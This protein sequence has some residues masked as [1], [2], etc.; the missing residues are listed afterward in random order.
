[1]G[2]YL[3]RASGPFRAGAVITFMLVASSVAGAQPNTPV[4]QP[5]TSKPVTP[6]PQPPSPTPPVAKPAVPKPDAPKPDAPKGSPPKPKAEQPKKVA[7]TNP[8]ASK[9]KKNKP[10]G[11]HGEVI[12]VH[13]EAPVRTKPRSSG[14]FTVDRKVIEAAP[15]AE[16]A[17]VLRTAPGLY[18][19][20]VS[21]ATAHRY[22]LRGFDAEHGQDLELRVGELPINLPSHIHGQG[23]ADLSFLI[24]EVV[25]R[26]DVAEGVYDPR[27]GDFGVAGSINASLG[28]TRRGIHVKSSLGRFG[29]SRHLLLWAPPKHDAHTFGAVQYTSTDGFGQNR[30]GQSVSAMLQTE[31]KATLWHHRLIGLVYGARSD[32]AGVLRRDDVAA[33]LVDFYGVYNQATARAQNALSGRVMLGLFSSYRGETGDGGGTGLW[34]GFDDFRLMSNFTGFLERS[35]TLENVAGRGDL[36]EQLNRT[37]SVGIN[38]HY[39]TKTFRP[40]PALRG[41]FELGTDA[42]FHVID[43]QQNL[44]DAAVRNQTWDNRVDANVRMADV[45]FWVD[46]DW[47]L[48]KRVGLRAGMRADAL[49]FDVEDRL[50]NF[51]PATRPDDSFIMG[52]RR[53]AFGLAA[54]P[55]ASADYWATDNLQLRVAYGEGFRSP[56][57][58][59]LEDGERAPFTKVRSADAGFRMVTEKVKL[60]ATGY[61]TRLSD[62]V[63]F[64]PSEGRVER[65]G[66]TRRLGGVLQVDVRPLDWLVANASVTYVDA[67]LLEPPPATADNPQPAF[68]PGQN[69]PFVPPLI[70]RADLGAHREFGYMSG[71]PFGARFGVG[72]NYLSPRPLPFGESSKQVA[73]LDVSAS[74]HWGPFE[75]GFELFNA[76]NSKY[77][78]VEFNFASNWNPSEPVR[79]VPARHF[80][81][82]SPLSWMATLQ[83]SL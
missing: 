1:V 61:F 56:Q 72:F 21:G 14:D 60:T 42:R 65:I 43:Q 77:A 70:L 16:G 26:L 27:Q 76:L 7:P 29:S 28:V 48:F 11:D 55:R 17:D 19:G 18:I 73:L 45:G 5:D 62:D 41:R 12:E 46:A 38:G 47:V 80:A 3:D 54:G 50:G 39:N 15:R 25:E 34:L 67:E 57:A 75:L 58:R 71:R 74:L 63:A 82:G 13:E 79:R 6:Q 53:S 51:A 2:T 8:D 4:S 49:M 31:H 69:L 24:G 68:E 33:G 78:A 59:T 20:R 66:R 52:Y 81:A 64:E 44:I 83:V 37:T 40:T 22:M 10:T 23:Y 9:A 30:R 35:R 32:L 36:I